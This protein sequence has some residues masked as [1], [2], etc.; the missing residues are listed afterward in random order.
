[1]LAVPANRQPALSLER[2]E[3]ATAWDEAIDHLGGH[4]LQSWRWGEVKSRHGWQPTRLLLRRGEVPVV[5]AQVLLRAVGPARV[6]YAPRGPAADGAST[7]DL[8]AFTAALDDVL[9]R[10]L[11]VALFLEPDSCHVVPPVSGTLG[12]RRSPDTVQPVRT[13]KVAVDR[14]DDELLGAMKPKTRYNVR[15]AERRGVTTRVGGPGDLLA[16][17]RLMEETA[18]RDHFGIH[19]VDYYRDVL[20]TFGGDAALI[21]AE[22]EGQLAAGV[23][24]VS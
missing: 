17:Y 5:A 6:G 20:D 22:I 14:Q 24:V 13:I 8:A 11:T 19:S 15:L 3:R 4:L 21:L 23:L 2:V 12:W 9:R 10:G 16:F 7:A 1:M 18:E